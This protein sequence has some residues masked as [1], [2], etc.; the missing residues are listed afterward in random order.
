MDDHFLDTTLYD[1]DCIVDI[2]DHHNDNDNNIDDE[3][4]L[5]DR[6]VYYRG[7]IYGCIILIFFIIV[8]YLGLCY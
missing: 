4:I 1:I 5:E 6:Y 3:D 8:I 7:C 2:I